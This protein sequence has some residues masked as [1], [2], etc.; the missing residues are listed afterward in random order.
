MPVV[1]I[2]GKRVNMRVEHAT[3]GAQNLLLTGVSFRR[4]SQPSTEFGRLHNIPADGSG[5]SCRR[6]ALALEA[7]NPMHD[8]SS[9]MPQRA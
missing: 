7:R 8:G 2:R 1:A 6:T 5:R 3:F 4:F 9:A